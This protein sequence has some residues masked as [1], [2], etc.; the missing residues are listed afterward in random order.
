M[1]STITFDKTSSP[2][3][4]TQVMVPLP[5]EFVAQSTSVSE[6]FDGVIEKSIVILE[7]LKYEWDAVSITIFST[8]MV[9]GASGPAGSTSKPPSTSISFVFLNSNFRY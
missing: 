5:F 2:S 3:P 7:P 6:V 8:G 9:T 4:F 1:S